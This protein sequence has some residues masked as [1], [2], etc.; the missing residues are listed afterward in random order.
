M[1]FLLAVI[2]KD[3][4]QAPSALEAIS[5]VHNSPEVRARVEQSVT[6]ARSERVLLAFRQYFPAPEP[7]RASDHKQG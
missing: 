5:R 6:R 4:R 2:E 7:D 1:D 3:P